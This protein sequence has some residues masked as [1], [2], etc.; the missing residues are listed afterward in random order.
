VKYTVTV[1]ER[2]VEVE[3]LGDRVRIGDR[4]LQAH[5]VHVPHTPIYRVSL[6]GRLQ[7]FA[8]QRGPQGWTAQA[9]AALYQVDVVDERTK[10]LREMTGQGARKAHTGAVKAPMP[11]LVL[12]VEVEPGQ[13][14]AAGRG[15]VVLEAMKMEN[16]IRAPAGG[17]IRAVLVKPGQAVEK[18]AALV[19]V[20]PTD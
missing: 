6:D 8:L 16:E 10:R 20:G 2:A 1:G 7:T 5:L 15:L 12:R 13:T 3:V 17:T 18:G 9:D 4:V 19:E 14:V 11:G